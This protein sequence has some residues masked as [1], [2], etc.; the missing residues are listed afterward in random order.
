MVVRNDQVR[1]A[2]QEKRQVGGEETVGTAACGSLYQI[3]VV[4]TILNL[5]CRYCYI[6]TLRLIFDTLGWCVF[7]LDGKT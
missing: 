2:V 5:Y 6:F 7:V 1:E 3:W 4:N